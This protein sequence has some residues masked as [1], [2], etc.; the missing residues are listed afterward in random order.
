MDISVVIVSYNVKEFLR[1]A[2][3]SV[4]RSFAAGH[5]TG[6]ILVVDNNSS[7]GSAAMMR[8][9]FPEICLY[10]LDENLGFGRANNLAMRDARGE[11]M[12]LL[13][14]DTIVGEDTLRFMIDFMQAHP[15]AG[16]AGCKLLNGDG[17]FQLSCR[18]GFPTPWASFTK[19]FGF[20]RMFPSSRVFAQYNLT[21]LPVDETYEVDALG[22]AFMML[23]QKAYHA[24]RGFDEDY[25]MYGEDIDLCYRTKQAGL[26]VY[27]VHETA[28]IHFKGESTKRSAIDEVNVF[29]EAM[30][31]FVKKN[32]GA[33][34][35]FSM[36]LRIGILLRTMLALGKKYRGAILL[37]TID[38]SMAMLGVLVGCKL[39][40]DRWSGL[41]AQDYPFALIIPPLIV[42]SLLAILRAYSDT[43]RRSPRQVILASPAI[44]IGLSSLT[45]FFK[46]FPSSRELVI[47]VTAMTCVFLLLDR[48][49]LRMADRLRWGGNSATNPA[50]RRTLVVGTDAEAVRIAR[51]LRRSQFIRRYEIA[52]FIDR[53]LERFHQEILPGVAVVGDMNM[54]PK[55]VRE[56]HIAEVIFASDSL[57]Y[58]EMLGAM[59]RVSKENLDSR[60]NFNMVP[61]ASDVLIGKRKIELLSEN[62]EQSLALMPVEYNLQ[63]L[64]HRAGKRA[65]DLAVSVA[66][67]PFLTFSY[68]VRPAAHKRDR[69]ELWK[70]VFRGELTLVGVAGADARSY[71]P[72]PGVTSLAAVAA[73]HNLHLQEL[74]AEDIEQFDRYYARN[75]SIGMDCEIFLKSIFFHHNKNV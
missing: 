46:E 62:P 24:T 20:A 75:H 25:F 33:S 56:N 74:R 54:L 1:G 7:D 30:H 9:E 6:E 8:A 70:R 15:D 3:E 23:S 51:L 65:L 45:Y 50:L 41:P 48:L 22:G 67:L 4:R 27:Y 49:V 10:A 58:T 68:F 31:I 26:K 34:P 53:S 69:L 12:L 61:S 29:Y 35:L 44:L 43:E 64:S 55:I 28:T 21:Y 42:V 59:Q 39:V 32:Y 47:G 5:L 71:F 2:I 38:Y 37:A 66:A 40:L 60:V 11:Y 73:P 16:L 13:N 14:P 63:R 18:R 72:K 36:M 52:G 19:L 57:P 17:S